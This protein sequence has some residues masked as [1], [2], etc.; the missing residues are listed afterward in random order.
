MSITWFKVLKLRIQV[1]DQFKRWRL[2]EFQLFQENL[3]N[4]E[5]RES[6]FLISFL[7][8]LSFILFLQSMLLLPNY[9]LPCPWYDLLI[10]IHHSLITL[11]S[12]LLSMSSSRAILWLHHIHS[13]HCSFF[14]C[15]ISECFMSV[16]LHYLYIVVIELCSSN[17]LSSCSSKC[18][19]QFPWFPCNFNR[20]SWRCWW[21]SWCWSSFTKSLMSR[22]LD[23]MLL[24]NCRSRWT[25][26]MI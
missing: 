4:F 6:F 24:S 12:L 5:Q 22:M 8:I 1:Y 19:F 2:T 23:S 10:L 14:F 17:F 15:S 25:W 9:V 21:P 13:H 3:I 26:M 18:Y 7:L 11:S 16:H 20:I